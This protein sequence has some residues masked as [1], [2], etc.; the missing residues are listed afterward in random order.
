MRRNR[1]FLATVACVGLGIFLLLGPVASSQTAA[2][3]PTQ[4]TVTVKEAATGFDRFIDLGRHNFSPGDMIVSIRK[5]LDPKTG[6]K[7]GHD[8]LRCN[9]V[10][11]SKQKQTAVVDCQGT[12]F[13]SAGR[14]VAAGALKFGP[15]PAMNTITITGGTGAYSGA[16][17]KAIAKQLKGGRTLLTFEMVLP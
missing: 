5:I 10:H 11:V 14:I 17:G 3:D 13:L 7:V 12:I 15:G 6:K 4:K 1:L 16:G 2:T 8:V 9:V